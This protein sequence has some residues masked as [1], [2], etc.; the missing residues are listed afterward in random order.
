[1]Q[2]IQMMVTATD[3]SEAR[4]VL[5]HFLKLENCIGGRI[6]QPSPEKPGWRV[7]AFHDAT[8]VSAS[9]VLPDGCQ[10]VT[11]PDSQRKA[12]GIYEET[13]DG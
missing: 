13:N 2:A 6:L 12:L 9:D 3:E 1:M 11:I 5:I 8:P 7:Q 10:L 4:A